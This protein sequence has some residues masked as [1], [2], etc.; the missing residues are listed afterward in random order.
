MRRAVSSAVVAT[1]TLGIVACGGAQSADVKLGAILSLQGAGSPYGQSIQRGIEMAVEDINAAGGVDVFEVGQKPL[2]L[3][4]RDARSQPATGLQA[5]HE[6]LAEG[7]TAAIGADVSDVTLAVA[8]VFQEAEV[9]LMSPASSTPT[10]SDAGDFIYRNFPS[11]DLEALNTADHVFNVA[12]VP[13]AAVI[14]Q[15]SEFG[16][17]QKNSFIQRF[18]LLGGRALG[19]GSYPANATPED[20]ATQ[21]Q[22]LLAEDPPAIYIAGYSADTALVARAIRDAG[23]DAALFG[24]GA[25]LPADLVAAGGDAVEG[26]AFPQAPFELDSDAD[27]VRKFVADYQAKYGMTPDVYAAHGYDAVQMI[28]LAISQAGLDG[29]ELRFYLNSMNPYEGLAGVTAFDDKGDV[30]KFHTMYAIQDGAAVRLE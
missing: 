28:A 27:N 11:D 22:R 26:L 16:L 3:L 21:V 6:L 19:Q 4:V 1:V 25:V 20:I 15:Q 18:R 24:T 8:P 30:R 12:H 14:A 29:H 13:E 17:G 9:L 5:A 10:L 2:T 23:S 7:V